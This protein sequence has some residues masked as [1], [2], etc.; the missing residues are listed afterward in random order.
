MTETVAYEQILTEVVGP[1]A[2][3]TLNRP[4]RMN[5]WT[6]QMSTEL[7]HAFNRFDL[8]DSVRAIV[9]TGA[10]RGFCAGADLVSAGGG[11]TF[12]G[13]GLGDRRELRERYPDRGSPRTSCRPRSSRRSTDRASA[14]A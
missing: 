2:I 12:S 9:V 3:V 6:W 11:D 4:D 7:T 13:S 14:R 10:G 1:V 8:D 5:A